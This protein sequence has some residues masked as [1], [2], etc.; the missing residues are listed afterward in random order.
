MR[1]GWSL[2]AACA[3][4]LGGVGGNAGRQVRA[5]DP[6]RT[7]IVEAVQKTRD[8]IVTI[9]VEKADGYGG[10]R[11]STG[12][13]VIVDERGYLVTSRHVIAAAAR[14]HI[15]LKDGTELPA[16]VV[17]AEKNTDLAILRVEPRQSLHPLALGPGS[18][19]LVGETVIAVGNPYGYSHT[20]SR[21]IISALGREVTMPSGEV[22]TNLIQIDAN[23]N[24]GNSGGP[25]LN[26]NG[27]VIGI[28][29]AIHSG[30]QGIAFAINVDTVKAMLSRHLSSLAL[31]GTRH[32]LTCAER[33]LPQGARRQRVVVAAV[34]AETPAAQA[35]LM[36]G[37]EIRQVDGRAVAN[38]FDVERALWD[39]K[40]GEQVPVAVSRQGKELAIAL[41]L[42]EAG[43]RTQRSV[44]VSATPE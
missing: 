24:P 2:A 31:A 21:G 27:E 32:G 26:I 37:D 3:V 36:R 43:P 1:I 25:L 11:D 13:G 9:K 6:R 33:V 44:P 14:L 42:R 19:L 10:T 39:H 20:V 22:L 5:Q 38:P 16:R 7:P 4:A 34:A 30:A 35:G 8:G 23:I 40:P 18:D 29:D 17:V 15:R 41:T 28:T 12:T